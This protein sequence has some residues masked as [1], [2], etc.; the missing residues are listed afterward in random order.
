M[1]RRKTDFREKDKIK[2]LLWCTRHCCLCEKFVGVG[3][4]IA[5]L[6]PDKSDLDN[7]IPLCFECHAAI[8][9][10]NAEHPRGRRYSVQELKTRRDQVYERYT[11]HL[12]SPVK[13]R[14]FRGNAT[15]PMVRFW[16]ANLGDTYPVR[17]RVVVTMFKGKRSHGCP[18]TAGHYDGRYLWNLNP[19]SEITGL[20]Y[21][22][23]VTL[24]N[25]S[26]P[27]KARVDLT[28]IDLYDREHTL[29]PGGYI[30]N[31]LN[32]KADWYFEPSVEELGPPASLKRR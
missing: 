5:H 19:K 12:V 25:P 20:F 31:N 28:V 21:F 13:Y 29:L 22:P 10:Y 11:R 6:D 15:L 16:L 17:V 7:A 2:I 27:L 23:K 14:V 3:I 24:R 26:V 9:H 1:A 8:G 18:R 4:E 30:L 32:A